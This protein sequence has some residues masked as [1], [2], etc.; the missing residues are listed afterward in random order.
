MAK[1][2]RPETDIAPTVTDSVEVSGPLVMAEPVDAAPEPEPDPLIVVLDEVKTDPA[3]QPQASR[4]DPAAKSSGFGGMVVGGVIAA[5]LGYGVAVY[6]PFAGFP[7][8]SAQTFEAA[9]ALAALGDR[10]ASLEAMPAPAPAVDTAL[11]DR[12]QALEQ[13]G[14]EPA[15]APD[16]S[17]LTGAIAAL[18]ARLAA[19]EAAPPGEGGATS[20]E[21]AAS[22]EALRAEVEGLRGSGTAMSA[23]I[24]AAAADA[25]ARLAEAEAQATQLKAEAEE[26]ARKSMARAAVSRLQAALESGAPFETALADL[27]AQEVPAVLTEAASV[28]IVSRAALEEAFPDAARSA[29]EASLQADMG[30]SLAERSWSFLQSTTGARSLAPREGTDPD[31]VLSRAEAAVK[32]GD[33][34]VA[35]TELQGLPPE[36]QAAM[37]D[38]IAK[39][40]K[41]Q[42]AADAVAALAAAI[43]G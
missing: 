27:P 43:E 9:A 24:A 21:L 35:L 29:L 38:F 25:Q 1:T 20:P 33:L 26:T 6:A 19:I 14:A 42:D 5:A 12:V 11:T 28:G 32:A 40:R 2:T 30:E 13:E 4:P 34:P 22:V 18:D 17:A 8:Q 39:V 41:R 7:G 23:E 15:D 37:A 10:V 3:P 16:F 36:G 31:A